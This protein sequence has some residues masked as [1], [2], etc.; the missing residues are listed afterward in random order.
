MSSIRGGGEELYLT[1]ALRSSI[2]HSSSVSGDALMS[3]TGFEARPVLM[4]SASMDVFAMEDLVER[5]S[6]GD[7]PLVGVME[8]FD[9]DLVLL[10]GPVDYASMVEVSEDISSPMVLRCVGVVRCDA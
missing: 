2:P 10:A 3:S 9:L 6:A 1:R 8:G 7:S 5:R 4:G